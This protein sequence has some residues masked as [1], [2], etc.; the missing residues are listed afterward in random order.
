[1]EHIV[2]TK[3]GF[4]RMGTTHTQQAPLLLAYLTFNCTINSWLRQ[5]DHELVLGIPVQKAGFSNHMAY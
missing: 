5:R 2:I 3:S 1:M 4:H